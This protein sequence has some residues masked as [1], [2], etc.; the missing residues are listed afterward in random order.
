MILF[1]NNNE[2]ND[3]LHDLTETTTSDE[4]LYEKN[5]LTETT[6]LDEQLYGK[7]FLAHSPIKRN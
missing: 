6:N 1:R 2:A 3:I 7:Q 4:Q 5:D